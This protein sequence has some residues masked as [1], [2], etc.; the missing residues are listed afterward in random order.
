MELLSSL[1]SKINLY[2]FTT[3]VLEYEP[4]LVSVSS[5]S[6]RDAFNDQPTPGWF[7]SDLLFCSHEIFNF[8]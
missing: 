3:C 5:I 8:N 7:P 1:N 4:V 6:C 2:F